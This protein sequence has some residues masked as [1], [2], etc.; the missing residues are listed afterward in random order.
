MN[1]VFAILFSVATFLV[2]C[3]DT[4]IIPIEVETPTST[5]MVDGIHFDTVFSKHITLEDARKELYSKSIKM[6]RDGYYQYYIKAVT[7]IRK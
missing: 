4:E 7:G 1:K 2:A 5:D 3:T 6:G